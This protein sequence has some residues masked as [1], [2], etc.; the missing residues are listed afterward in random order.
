MPNTKSAEKRVRSSARKQL[1]NRSV[2]SRLRRV[3]KGLRD[4]IIAGKKA[5][6]TKSLPD[7]LSVIDKA[8][9]SGVITRA[10]ANRKKSRLTL[11]LNR[12]K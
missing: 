12:A 3:E 2:S 8:V 11:A 5:D 6:A 1:Q 10:A 9:K 7:A 4:T